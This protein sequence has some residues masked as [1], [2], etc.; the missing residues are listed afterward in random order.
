VITIAPVADTARTRPGEEDARA[1]VQ[2][3]L[4]DCVTLGSEL[5]MTRV[6]GQAKSLGSEAFLRLE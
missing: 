5:G 3:L 4:R 1:R 2:S 6:V